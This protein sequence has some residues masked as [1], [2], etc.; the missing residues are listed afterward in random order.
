[1]TSPKEEM[2]DI[3]QRLRQQIDALTLEQAD[4]LKRATYLG[5]T[6]D[7]AKAYD[8]RRIKITELMGQLVEIRQ[9]QA[10]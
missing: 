8:A 3:I 4:A 5:M 2:A 10:G 7:E 6:P 9:A 1:M